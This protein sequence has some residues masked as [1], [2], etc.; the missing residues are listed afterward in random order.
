MPI[1]FKSGFLYN[2]IVW[3]CGLPSHEW[4]PTRRV[5]E[6]LESLT[7]RAELGL[8]VYRP[9]SRFEFEGYLFAEQLAD[10]PPLIHIDCH[11]DTDGILVGDKR[12]KIPWKVVCDAIRPINVK[13]G[14]RI[15]VV[16]NCCFSIHAIFAI[17]ILE[18]TPFQGFVGP[19]DVL[20]V[21][22]FER[23]IPRFYE[24]LCADP[25]FS[26]ALSAL[27]GYDFWLA[28]Q[29]LLQTLAGFMKNEATGKGKRRFVEDLISQSRATGKSLLSEPVSIPRERIKGLFNE[30]TGPDLLE[31][32]IERFLFGQRPE[33]TYDDLVKLARE[34]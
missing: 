34:A 29:F 5:L 1:S 28:D 21:R 9:A 22:E 32:H 30:K 31:S 33:F 23:A 3:L 25:N 19:T 10:A 14:N 15:L 11:G 16:S 27:E 4:G 18:A 8:K 20:K 2:R 7:S 12:E 17:S 24:A 26:H 6:D 13:S